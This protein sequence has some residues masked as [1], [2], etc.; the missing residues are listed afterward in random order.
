MARLLHT[1]WTV[2]PDGGPV[3]EHVLAAGPVP[4]VVPGTVHTDLLAAGLI[5]DPYLDENESLLAWIGL[6]DRLY[7]TTVSLGAVDGERR[8]LVLHGLDTV[9]TVEVDGRVVLEAADAQ[10]QALGSRPCVN[11][12]P[13]DAVRKMACNFGW[14]WGP[15]LVSA[16]CCGPTYGAR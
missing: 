2:G 5:P 16:C 14:D 12:H 6:P 3:P 1:G 15:D 4:A 8:V 11:H 10:Q 13:D 7:E 9:A